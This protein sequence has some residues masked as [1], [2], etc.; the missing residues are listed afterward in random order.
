MS[1]DRKKMII[2]IQLIFPRRFND[3]AIEQQ[4]LSLPEAALIPR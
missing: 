3:G 1:G 2:G 4:R